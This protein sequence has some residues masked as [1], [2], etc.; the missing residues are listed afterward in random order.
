MKYD[1]AVIYNGKFYAAGDD[2]PSGAGVEK[3]ASAPVADEPVVEKRRAGRPPKKE[4]E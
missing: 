4:E 3:K 2:V 1:H